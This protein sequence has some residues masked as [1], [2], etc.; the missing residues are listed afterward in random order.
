[1]RVSRP[2]TCSRSRDCDRPTTVVLS[3]SFAGVYV[4]AIALH[5]E[6]R[7][8]DLALLLRERLHLAAAAA[9]ATAAAAGPGLRLAE[10]LAERTDAQEVQVARRRTGSGPPELSSARA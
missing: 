6:G 7:R 3:R 2:S 1:M 5:V 9:T 10:V 4:P 8:D